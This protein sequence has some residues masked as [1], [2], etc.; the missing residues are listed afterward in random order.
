MTQTTLRAAN[1]TKRFGATMAL[2]NVGFD[3]IGGQIHG[4]VGENGAG[5]STLIRILGGVHKP[6]HGEIY[7][8]GKLRHFSGPR[9]AIA[10]GIATIPQE[11]RL[12]PSLSIAENM[13]LGDWPVTGWFGVP[14]IVDRA[15]MHDDARRTLRLLNF[16]PNL[17]TPVRDLPFGERQLVAIGKALR[18]NCRVLILDE[19][20]AA[21]EKHEI[22]RL[23]DVLAR[24]K[25]AGV[26]IIYISHHLD[27]IVSLA[28]RCTVL[29]DGRVAAISRRGE[30]DKSALV[31]AM[32]GGIVSEISPDAALPG[33]TILEEPQRAD[34]ISLRAGELMGL[35]GLL[36]SGKERVLR[37]LFATG[38][39][40]AQVRIRG[41]PTHLSVPVQAVAAG[42]GMV[43][44]E[45]G[46]G[47]IMNQSVRD[48]IL[49]ASLDRVPGFRSRD[50]RADERT[51]EAL[52][53]LLDIRPRRPELKVSMLSGGNQQKVILAKWLARNV[54]ILLLDDPTQG[55]DV[56][57]KAQI[58]ALLRD[59]AK[60]GGAVLL[61]SSDLGELAR[62]CHTVIAIH[63]GRIGTRMDRSRLTEQ[64][65]LRAIGGG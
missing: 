27:E 39:E 57:A 32:T 28:E 13:A 5:K 61:S 45:R 38:R 48:N 60:R 9:D 14:G 10:A 17:E 49:L 22:D 20:T 16:T 26:A 33:Q 40:P 50:R 55:I 6:D 35:A 44:G 7:L 3:V 29:R 18:R 65:L 30:F 1:I 51:V 62:L 25:N 31:E 53:E 47:L 52:L 21:L 43:P 19:P 46:L 15:R 23:F 12:V 11:L 58:H 36:G 56:S 24:M 34:G 42:I 63:R 64:G 4:L 54:D 2:D 37:R 41:I 59:F 8:E